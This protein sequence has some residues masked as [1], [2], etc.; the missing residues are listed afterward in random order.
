MNKNRSKSAFFNEK[1]R[2][3]ARVGINPAPFDRKSKPENP[4]KS[5]VFG[6]L[7]FA[8]DIDFAEQ[9]KEVRG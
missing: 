5:R 7:H 8:L 9:V 1:S 4:C 3:R 2:A 6:F